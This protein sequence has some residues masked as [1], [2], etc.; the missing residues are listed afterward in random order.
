MPRRLIGDKRG[1]AAL[2]FAMV[3]PVFI[4]LVV[5]FF[6]LGLVMLKISMLDFAVAESAKFIYTTAAEG[7][8]PTQSEMK[9]FI[10]DRA[11]VL[12]G[13][14]DNIAVELAPIDAFG[15]TPSE[16]AACVDSASEEINPPVE[17]STGASNQVMFMRVCVTTN[18][19]SPA[20]RYS[21]GRA[22]IKS[23]TG[24][25]EILSTIA[26]MNE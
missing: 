20:V 18:I 13:C 12:S 9:Q 21:F 7:D 15:A 1:A 5:S 4:G 8:P 10:C 26:F 17:Y 11:K 19:I 25:Q 16:D 22:L 14:A 6:E 2:E 3:G 24:R 23:D